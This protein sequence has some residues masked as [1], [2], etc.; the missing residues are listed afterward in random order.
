MRKYAFLNNKKWLIRYY[1]RKI[2][3]EKINIIHGVVYDLGCGSKPYQCLIEKYSDQYI[4]VD[5]GN[6]THEK[7]MDVN[8]DLNEKLPIDNHVAD[9]VI[10]FQVMEHLNNPEKFLE[11]AYRILK[12]DGIIFLTVPFQ[13]QV[14][15][16]P[17]DYYRYTEFGLKYLFE[18]TGFSDITIEGAGGFWI[19]I[20]NKISYHSTRWV[21]GPKFIRNILRIILFLFRFAIQRL[22][23]V[24]DKVDFN[25]KEALLYSV[26]AKK[27]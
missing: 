8:A 25:E 22:S 12:K 9:A 15:E 6:T 26:I 11:E 27:Y 13:H 21:K 1:N 3:N 2:I 24:L 14:H 23:L 4:G 17:Y 20:A 7:V 5:W 10:S 18:K 19:T 16:M